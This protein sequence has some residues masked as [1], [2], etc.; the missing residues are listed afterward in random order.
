MT[1]NYLEHSFSFCP[2]ARQ[3]FNLLQ[4]QSLRFTQLTLTIRETLE[5]Q[6]C[7]SGHADK[8]QVYYS[9]KLIES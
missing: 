1:T 5:H 4:S 3:F 8:H 7:L 2:P 9:P 6:G